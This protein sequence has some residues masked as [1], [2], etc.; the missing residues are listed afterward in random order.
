MQPT[1]PVSIRTA[2]TSVPDEYDQ[3]AT[4]QHTRQ[5][6][7]RQERL[8]ECRYPLF[9]DV[10]E[11]CEHSCTQ[12]SV[13]C[14]LIQEVHAIYAREI[15]TKPKFL[16]TSESGQNGTRTTREELQ[17]LARLG[18]ER[19]S[20]FYPLMTRCKDLCLDSP[21]PCRIWQEVQ[22]IHEREMDA[23]ER[24]CWESNWLRMGLI[25]KKRLA[26]ERQDQQS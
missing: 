1:E 19:S 22:R 21:R 7:E 5:E 16:M 24:E 20:I 11:R 4:P 15:G 10:R 18:E 9:R 25:L 23:Q 2:Q 12:G 13:P 3:P 26:E 8:N 6:L 14:P 17:R